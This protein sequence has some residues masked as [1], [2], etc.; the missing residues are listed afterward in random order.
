M[1]DGDRILTSRLKGTDLLNIS[2]ANQF[3]IFDILTTQTQSLRISD[4]QHKVKIDRD[5]YHDSKRTAFELKAFAEMKKINANS[6]AML[7]KLIV[8]ENRMENV[9]KRLDAIYKLPAISENVRKL[10]VAEQPVMIPTEEEAAGHAEVEFQEELIKVDGANDDDAISNE[11]ELINTLYDETARDPDSSLQVIDEMELTEDQIL[12]QKRNELIA[13]VKK[14]HGFDVNL[15]DYD[16]EEEPGFTYTKYG[17][18]L[19]DVQSRNVLGKT[20]IGEPTDQHGFHSRYGKFWTPDMKQMSSFEKAIPRVT[21]PHHVEE[22]I[23]K[24][25]KKRN[26]KKAI[27]DVK[28]MAA[29]IA[30]GKAKPSTKKSKPV[31]RRENS[32]EL[33]EIDFESDDDDFVKPPPKRRRTSARKN[34]N[35]SEK[36]KGKGKNSNN[37]SKKVNPPVAGPSKAPKP[38]TSKLQDKKEKKNIEVTPDSSNSPR[39]VVDLPEDA[40]SPSRKRGIQEPDETEPLIKKAK[41]VDLWADNLPFS[42]KGWHS[43]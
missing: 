2:I 11:D 17:D 8:I 31:K 42:D 38:S 43:E 27:A 12:T 35:A 5:T 4:I 10:F 21:Q 26:L 28:V 19:H 14:T 18:L 1:K 34:K 22:E 15:E 30:A 29:G 20:P 24:E 39:L 36:G 3:A 13:S 6:N 25:E 9:E 40:A 32:P 7:K 16:N 23:E 37:S 33:G 41:I